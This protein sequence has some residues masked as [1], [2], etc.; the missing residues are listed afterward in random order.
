MTNQSKPVNRL[1]LKKERLVNITPASPFN[2]KGT[3]MDTSVQST[4]I[5]RILT[6]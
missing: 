4:P 2:A 5:C 3:D 6:I 1:V